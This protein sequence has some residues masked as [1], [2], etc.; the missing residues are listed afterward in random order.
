MNEKQ[1]EGLFIHEC[2]PWIASIYKGPVFLAKHI[3][4]SLMELVVISNF[5]PQRR[6]HRVIKLKTFKF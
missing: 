4:R 2:L 3:Q 1:L 5:T 6:P